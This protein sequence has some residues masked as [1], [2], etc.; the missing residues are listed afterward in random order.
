MATRQIKIKE[1]LSKWDDF[2]TRRKEVQD[3]FIKAKKKQKGLQS[4]LVLMN[5]NLILKEFG[6]KIK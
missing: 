5:V 4:L 1:N 2:R 3:K 6:D